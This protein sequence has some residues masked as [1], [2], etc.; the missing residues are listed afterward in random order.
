MESGG[1]R[2]AER[3]EQVVQDGAGE[4]GL[5]AVGSVGREGDLAVGDDGGEDAQPLQPAHRRLRR[6]RLVRRRAQHEE[7][8]LAP[9]LARARRPK[10]ILNAVAINVVAG[11][12]V[13][14]DPHVDAV[15]AQRADAARRHGPAGEHGGRHRRFS[16]GS[17]SGSS[18]GSAAV[19]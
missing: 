18:A 8:V 10:R 2:R 13:G 1:A 6:P 17:S 19:S 5:R 3:D 16:S 9:P 15:D 4:R 11:A 12:V 14:A 7:P